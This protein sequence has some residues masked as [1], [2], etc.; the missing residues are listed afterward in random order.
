MCED[1]PRSWRA[2]Q[3]VRAAAPARTQHFP[4]PFLPVRDAHG[5]PFHLCFP[6]TRLDLGVAGG[7]PVLPGGAAGRRGSAARPLRRRRRLLA[8]QARQPRHHRPRREPAILLHRNLPGHG[9]RPRRDC[10]GG[11]AHRSGTA[12]GRQSRGGSDSAA[13][14]RSGGR[15]GLAGRRIR[16][17]IAGPRPGKGRGS[18]DRRPLPS[19]RHAWDPPDGPGNGLR[20]RTAGTWET[21]SRRS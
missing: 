5:R 4:T 10:T 16:S 7:E 19:D 14:L 13:A 2:T 15:H 20:L 18:R 9:V 12:R 8:G 11:P 17:P 1:S 21:R 3:F 6:E